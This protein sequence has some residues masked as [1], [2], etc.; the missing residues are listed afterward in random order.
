MGVVN[1]RIIILT[2]PKSNP[3]IGVP[4]LKT[5]KIIDEVQEKSIY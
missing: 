1:M 2:V 5:E 4:I 3:H